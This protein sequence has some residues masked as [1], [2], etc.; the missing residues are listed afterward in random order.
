MAAANELLF[1]ALPAMD[2]YHRWIVSALPTNM[3]G[4]LRSGLQGARR[5]RSTVAR[6]NN[7][8]GLSGRC[9]S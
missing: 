7:A 6:N 3:Q 2:V 4:K 5:A 1:P 9:N 8:S